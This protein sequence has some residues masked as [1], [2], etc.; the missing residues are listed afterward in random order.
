MGRGRKLWTA[1]VFGSMFLMLATYIATSSFT[2]G[3]SP[4]LPASSTGVR[5]PNK[6]TVKPSGQTALPTMSSPIDRTGE[7]EGT[8]EVAT[9]R[10]NGKVA[11]DPAMLVGRQA[12]VVGCGT[13]API[14]AD[15]T[16]ELDTE[17]KPCTLSAVV[18]K[19]DGTAAFGDGVMPS[20]RGTPTTDGVERRSVDIRGPTDDDFGTWDQHIHSQRAM[21]AGMA[22]LCDDP[23]SDFRAT[24][25]A[26][27]C[28]QQFSGEMLEDLAWMEEV[29]PIIALLSEPSAL[30]SP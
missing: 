20:L 13:T 5:P 8:I 1:A 24:S 23:A 12:F 6:P 3:P 4:K 2:R 11:I 14:R 18:M 15:L 19:P 21:I 22:K 10:Y 9:V 16:F 17:P 30:Q 29:A 7:N 27:E 28:V 25:T 26:A